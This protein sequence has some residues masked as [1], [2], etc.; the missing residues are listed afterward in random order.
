MP[1]V[2]GGL[3]F[4]PELEQLVWQWSGSSSSGSPRQPQLVV[5][6]SLSLTGRM[7]QQCNFKVEL[8]VADSR[9]SDSSSVSARLHCQ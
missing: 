4:E 3:A 5:P 6:V 7:L 1:R 9:L 8:E 2:S